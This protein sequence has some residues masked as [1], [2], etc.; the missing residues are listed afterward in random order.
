MAL[1]SSHNGKLTG[2]GEISVGL[3]LISF[4]PLYMDCQIVR[5]CRKQNQAPNLYFKFCN[6]DCE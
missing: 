3:V 5:L 1:K 6:L 2:N 4:V